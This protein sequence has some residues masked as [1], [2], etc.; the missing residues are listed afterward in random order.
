MSPAA[1]NEEQQSEKTGMALLKER[2]FKLSRCEYK[3]YDA[4]TRL[5]D[6]M[7]LCIELAI[8]VGASYPV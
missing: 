7:L 5:T 4:M 6:R 3:I 2:R 1:Q 8:G